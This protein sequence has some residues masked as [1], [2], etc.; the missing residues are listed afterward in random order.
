[1]LLISVF[2][3]NQTF[4]QNQ[5]VVYKHSTF[6]SKTDVNQIS[7]NTNWGVGFDFV[8]RSKNELGS[9]SIFTSMLRESYRP[10]LHY[11]FSPNARLSVS[12]LG[13]MRTAEY[14]GTTNDYDRLPYQEF[15]TTFQF[16]HHHK[17]AGGRVMHTWRYRYE[18][19]W[20]D[21][22][23]VDELRYLN[24]FRFRY[25]IRVGLNSSDFYANNTLYT[26]V[27]NEI[28]LNFGK[29][30]VYNTFNQNRLYIGLGYRFLTAARVELRYVDRFRTRGGTGFEFD[31]DRGVMLGIYIDQVSLLGT[32]DI[33]KVRFFD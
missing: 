5:K 30:I 12:P 29:N 22:P 17:Q 7:D 24:R 20:Q 15:R 9:G 4:A 21:I 28:G 6:W 10:W 16:F 27:S 32:K 18:M 8:Y 11:Q 1:M 33:L 13:F 3:A 14:I 19:R 31:H 2:A 26:A 23:G 25:R